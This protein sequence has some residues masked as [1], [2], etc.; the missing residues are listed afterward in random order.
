[1]IKAFIAAVYSEFETVIVPETR[2]EQVDG[3]MGAPVGNKV[4]L[5]FRHIGSTKT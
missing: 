2:I 5:G 1:V 3:L 4:M